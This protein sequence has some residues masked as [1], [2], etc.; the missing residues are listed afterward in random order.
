M[1]R[2]IST[3]TSSPSTLIG[4]T[5]TRSDEFSSGTPVLALYCHP[6]HGQITLPSITMPWPSGPPRC[7]QTLSIADNSPSTLA[8]QTNLPPTLNSLASPGSGRSDLLQTLV[9]AGIGSLYLEASR[10]WLTATSV[11][12]S[13]QSSPDA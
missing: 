2:H 6:C 4:Y 9:K 3:S 13:A 1:A 12:V 10:W 11:A 7:T 8:T 5:A